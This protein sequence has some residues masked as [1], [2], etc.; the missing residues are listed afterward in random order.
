MQQPYIHFV[1]DAV[2]VFA[3]ALHSLLAATCG[4]GTQGTCPG[5]IEAAHTELV[6]H[7]ESI[8]FNDV[9]NFPFQF[10]GGTH[11]GP[12][13]YS[14]ISYM[15]NGEGIVFKMSKFFFIKIHVGFGWKEVGTYQ[16]GKIRK[17]DP[18]F[19]RTV[20][21]RS[22][23]ENFVQCDQ[24]TCEKDEIKIPDGF[25]DGCCWHCQVLSIS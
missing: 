21:N 13:R 20:R 22:L 18:D 4:E 5:F 1:R 17:L 19:E 3:H 11:D 16:N 15:E 8:T 6:D 23:M 14:I 10:E 12:P 9:D 2:Y 25:N 24:K 7:L